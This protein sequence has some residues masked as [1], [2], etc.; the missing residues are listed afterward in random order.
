MNEIIESLQKEID[1]SYIKMR[2]TKKYFICKHAMRDTALVSN[3]NYK[4]LFF[5]SQ[6]N[7]QSKGQHHN[8]LYGVESAFSSISFRIV[9]HDNSD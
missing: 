1:L 3:S 9:A 8:L 4:H 2:M 7:K 5:F 6:T